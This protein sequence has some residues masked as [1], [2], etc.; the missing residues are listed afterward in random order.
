L[1]ALPDIRFGNSELRKP[2]FNTQNQPSEKTHDTLYNNNINNNSNNI[3][4]YRNIFNGSNNIKEKEKYIKRKRKVFTKKEEMIEEKRMWFL[5]QYNQA[6][7]QNKNPN[8]VSAY[9]NMVKY[10]ISEKNE[11]GEP[12]VEILKIPKQIAF[13]QLEKLMDK[14]KASLSD[15]L[16]AINGLANNKTYTK[17]KESLY[18]TVVNWIKRNQKTI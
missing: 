17:Y 6:K 1:K 15:I 14:Y 13:H 8:M 4:G 2:Q 10:I 7:S 9:A 12:L 5:E 3:S 16:D 11:F 18:L